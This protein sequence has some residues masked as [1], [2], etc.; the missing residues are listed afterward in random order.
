MSRIWT[1][2]MVGVVISDVVFLAEKI[3]FGGGQRELLHG[4]GP[5]MKAPKGQELLAKLHN[6]PKDLIHGGPGPWGRAYQL[7]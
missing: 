4:L 5:I 3:V 2:V 7:D 1:V 6:D